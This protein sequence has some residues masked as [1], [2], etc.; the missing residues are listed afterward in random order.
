MLAG[1]LGWPSRCFAL[2]DGSPEPRNGGCERDGEGVIL[3]ALLADIGQSAL[4]QAIRRKPGSTIE[5]SF[6]EVYPV[7]PDMPLV[8]E[9]DVFGL[10]VFTVAPNIQYLNC[11]KDLRFTKNSC[12][13]CD[14][15]SIQAEFGRLLISMNG[16]TGKGVGHCC[17]FNFVSTSSVLIDPSLAH[18]VAASCGG[19][20]RFAGGP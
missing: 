5:P 3:L 12:K 8:G 2:H 4:E 1:H 13:S 20:G 14:P 11:S 9:D 17:G 18:I 15:L 16:P 10:T 19:K 6:D 7:D